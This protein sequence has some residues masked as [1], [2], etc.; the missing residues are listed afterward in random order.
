MANARGDQQALAVPRYTLGRLILC[1]GRPANASS[2]GATCCHPRSRVRLWN[3]SHLG[4]N[5]IGSL[6][7][8]TFGKFTVFLPNCPSLSSA[9]NMHLRPS[10]HHG[11]LECDCGLM[12]TIRHQLKPNYRV[13]QR[14]CSHGVKNLIHL[15]TMGCGASS[16]STRTASKPR[17]YV[18]VR[19]YNDAALSCWRS[20]HCQFLPLFDCSSFTVYQEDNG[21]RLHWG[22]GSWNGW[23]DDL[24]CCAL[25]LILL[26][27][28][29]R[30]N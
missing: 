2:Q 4:P 20:S 18:S 22:W 13:L 28:L 15:L 21:I 7:A 11:R 3:S 9:R 6:T 8:L 27:Y 19:R 10:R 23:L 1:L 14:F 26:S 25:F 17:K 29:L 12:A 24:V 5:K 30:S 16:T